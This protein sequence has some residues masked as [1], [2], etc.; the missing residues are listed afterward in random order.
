MAYAT[1]GQI[2]EPRFT[3]HLALHLPSRILRESEEEI[4]LMLKRLTSVL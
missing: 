4:S 2:V 3:E 1:I